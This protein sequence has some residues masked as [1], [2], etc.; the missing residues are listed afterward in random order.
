MRILV[1][2]DDRQL[3]TL[4]CAILRTAG[5]Q[6]TPAFDGATTM[7]AAMRSPA[8]ELIVLDLAMPA[9]TGQATLVKLKQ[10]S[11]TNQIPVLV[12]T[13][14]TDATTRNEVLSMGAEAFLP[15]PVDAD[16]LL[17][18]VSAIKDVD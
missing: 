7:M 13:A 18:A 9:G 8:P 12:L 14:S 3:S 1:A 6:P 5:H 11:R 16:A 15:K 4:L 2:D 17:A 10:S